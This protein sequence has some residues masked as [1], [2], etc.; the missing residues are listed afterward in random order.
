MPLCFES[1]DEVKL[2]LPLN[3]SIASSNYRFFQ[4]HLNIPS[5][6][7]GFLDTYTSFFVRLLVFK[8]ALQSSPA[9]AFG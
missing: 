1:Q 5:W 8:D 6:M 3:E 2:K 9:A 4:V 7:K